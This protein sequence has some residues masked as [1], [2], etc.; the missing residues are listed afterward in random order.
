MQKSRLISLLKGLSNSEIKAVKKFLLSSYFNP[1]KKC[2]QLYVY[3]TRYYPDFDSPKLSKEAVFYKIFPEGRKYEGGNMRRLMSDLSKLIE[4]FFILQELSADQEQKQLYLID[5]YARRKLNTELASTTKALLNKEETPNI[6]FYLNRFLL[7]WK[8]YEN[9]LITPSTEYVYF[10]N[11]LQNLDLFFAHSKLKLGLEYYNLTKRYNLKTPI[12]LIRA[13][14]EFAKKDFN[15]EKDILLLHAELLDIMEEKDISNESFQK[16]HIYLQK[17]ISV[18]TKEDA[19]DILNTL[20][21]YANTQINKGK[22]EFQ[23]SCFDLLKTG[24]AQSL[25]INK[26]TFSSM[27]FLNICTIGSKLGQ[28]TWV[29]QFIKENQPFLLPQKRQITIYQC[30]SFIEFF[31]GIKYNRGSHFRQALDILANAKFANLKDAIRIKAQMLRIQYELFAR[32]KTSGL[33]E[34]I[35]KKIEGFRKVCSKK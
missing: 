18:L 10:T 24:L 25:F 16:I 30:Q 19:L 20:Y 9:Q 3:L 12:F 14:K 13:V 27:V 5:A 2:A 21:N 22:K 33:L 17:S 31:K 23:S 4:Q 8:L 35:Q 29:E 1:K 6:Q 32:N 28:F 7:N 11:C 26:G 34:A 15:R